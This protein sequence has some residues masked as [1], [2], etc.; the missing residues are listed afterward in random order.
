MAAV[1]EALLSAQFCQK[2][3]SIVY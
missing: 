3:L 2:S 1:L